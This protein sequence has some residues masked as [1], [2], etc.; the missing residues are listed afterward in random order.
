MSTTREFIDTWFHRVWTE[1][2]TSAIEEMFV[3]D[4]R[5]EGLGEDIG[6]GPDGFKKFHAEVCGLFDDIVITVDRIIERDKWV[7]SLCTFR[8]K[9]RDTG[10]AVET[11]GSM[12]FRIAD[13][14]IAEVY[15]HWDYL[16]LF[17]SMKLLPRHS[18]ERGLRGEKIA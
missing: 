2:D 18:L 6:G 5:T 7:S 14:K 10:E 8:S 9:R 12:W 4:G 11:T 15:N 3:P 17:E 1:Q 13:G 16:G